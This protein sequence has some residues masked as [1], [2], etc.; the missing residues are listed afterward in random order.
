MIVREGC[1]LFEAGKQDEKHECAR[2]ERFGILVEEE[3]KDVEE[4]EARH[5]LPDC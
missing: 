5:A 3:W 2:Q 4:M 1:K